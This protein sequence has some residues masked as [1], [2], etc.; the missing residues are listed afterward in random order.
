MTSTSGYTYAR[1]CRSGSEARYR[2]IGFETLTSGGLRVQRGA[3][4]F[5]IDACCCGSTGDDTPVTVG[6]FPYGDHDGHRTAA[7]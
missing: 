2:F 3:W 1:A 7:V 6:A 5:S 4:A